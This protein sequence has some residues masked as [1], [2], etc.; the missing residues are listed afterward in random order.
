VLFHPVALHGGADGQADLVGAGERAVR[1]AVGDC[2][3]GAFGGAEQL[4]ALAGALG[5]DERVATDDQPL[6]RVVLRCGDLGRV[7]LVKQRQLQRPDGDELVD[8]RRL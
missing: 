5:G 1:D 4:A 2:V 8:L 6:A 7:L 3:Q